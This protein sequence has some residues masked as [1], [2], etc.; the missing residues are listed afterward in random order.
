MADV[1]VERRHALPKAQA[2]ALAER[3]LAELARRYRAETEWHG[4]VL[5]FQ[6]PGAA[7]EV[8]LSDAEIRVD[9]KLGLLLR[10]LKARIEQRIAEHLDRALAAPRAKRAR[11]PVSKRRS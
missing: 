11:Q 9:V 1:R 5:R 8:R 4:D 6:A 7:G 3:A 10:P 2:R